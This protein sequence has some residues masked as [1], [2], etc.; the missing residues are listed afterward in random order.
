MFRRLLALLASLAVLAAPLAAGARDSA[1]PVYSNSEFGFSVQFPGAP[2]VQRFSQPVNGAPTEQVIANYGLGG[3]SGLM[4]MVARFQGGFT[5]P[6][7][8]LKGAADGVV[9]A[10][11]GKVL[12]RTSLQVQGAPAELIVAQ[13]EGDYV[14]ADLMVVKDGVIYQLMSVGHGALPKETDAFHSSFTFLTAP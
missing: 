8:A 2:E 12:S 14:I 13:P 1:W 4:I 3:D 10:A 7:A 6:A 5:D 11:N 9:K